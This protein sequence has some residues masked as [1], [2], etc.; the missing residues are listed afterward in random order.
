[1]KATL[2]LIGLGALAAAAPTN[3]TAIANNGIT[4]GHNH[5][6]A[7]AIDDASYAACDYILRN[8]RTSDYLFPSKYNNK[9]GFKLK[10]DGP[11]Y[12][13][14]ILK[15]GYIYVGGQSLK[16]FSPRETC[17]SRMRRLTHYDIAGNAGLDRVVI[18]KKCEEAGQITR[19][20][21]IGGYVG[22]SGT[23]RGE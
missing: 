12:M 11:F 7:K 9:E 22:C 14:P 20:G 15:S 16:S 8:D 2:A 21:V 1:M 3:M 6:T 19:G 13:F 17:S 18:N 23:T 5:Y 4:C 10:G